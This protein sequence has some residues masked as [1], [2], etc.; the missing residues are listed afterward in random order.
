MHKG[1]PRASA[2]G[3]AGVACGEV[4]RA[5]LVWDGTGRGTSL[6]ANR[7]QQQRRSKSRRRNGTAEGG[8]NNSGE[9]LVGV[10]RPGDAHEGPAQ[11]AGQGNSMASATGPR[12]LAAF[13][14]PT[15][16][17]CDPP[18]HHTSAPPRPHPE[19]LHLIKS[20]NASSSLHFNN[21]FRL[22]IPCH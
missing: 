20:H 2:A 9:D 10:A 16:H 19:S 5:E 8:N 6:L 21:L 18:P 4:A 17:T 1:V 11:V 7:R 15:I 22:P 13:G 3:A 14:C 12:L